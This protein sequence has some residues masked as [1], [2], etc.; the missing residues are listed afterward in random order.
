[1]QKK[2]PIQKPTEATGESFLKYL[3]TTEEYFFS[4]I[5]NCL[6]FRLNIL[7]L[8]FI[9]KMDLVHNGSYCEA[10][11]DDVLIFS[12]FLKNWCGTGPH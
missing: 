9:G 3:C 10:G 8:K 1:M 6:A 2:N 5:L 11:V 4:S 7:I 12:Y